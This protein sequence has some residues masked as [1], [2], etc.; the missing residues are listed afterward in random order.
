MVGVARGVWLK[1]ISVQVSKQFILLYLGLVPEL[2]V[3]FLFF[4]ALEP[5]ST[6]IGAQG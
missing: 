6:G 1:P 5:E 3:F 2:I 4:L